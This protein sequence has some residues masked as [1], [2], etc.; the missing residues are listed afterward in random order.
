MIAPVNKMSKK[1]D[2]KQQLN[3]LITFKHISSAFTEASAVKLANIRQAFKRNDRFFT[4]IIHIYNLV[5]TNAQKQKITEASKDLVQKKITVALTSNHRFFGHLNTAIMQK[6]LNYSQK[7]STDRLVIGTTGDSF[8]RAS[9]YN[10]KYQNINFQTDSPTEAERR[11]FLEKI[12]D[13]ASVT[14]FFPKFISIIR[15][16][17]G[18][19]DISG[20]MEKKSS[21]AKDTAF[22]SEELNILFEPEFSKILKFFEN[23]VKM[24]L[25]KRVILE[26]ELA[27]TAARLLEMSQAEERTDYEINLKNVELRKVT[28]SMINANLLE[29][30][31]GIKKW[32]H[33]LSEKHYLVMEKNKL[34]FK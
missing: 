30:F 25:F 20:Q 28:S 16:E 8:M 5:L 15:Q 19:I 12:K 13:Y 27:R 6:F 24:I 29:T 3:D 32:K 18:S 4:D 1:T 21:D 31:S 10:V 14:L 11:L 22:I 2:I 23:E 17:V 34:L 33:A 7:L 9:N 26:T